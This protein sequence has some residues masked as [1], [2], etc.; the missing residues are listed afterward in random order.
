MPAFNLDKAVAFL[1]GL[2]EDHEN[3]VQD[4]KGFGFRVAA[5]PLKGLMTLKEAQTIVAAFEKNTSELRA[6]VNGLPNGR[7][8]PTE[9]A[10]GLEALYKK[11]QAHLKKF[12]E[13]K[14]KA[15]ETLSKYEDILTGEHFQEAFQAL[16]LA[17]LDLDLTDDADIDFK[18]TLY[19][20]ADP[21]YASGSV[22]VKKGTE[23]VLTINLG[24]R[25]SDDRYWGNI[26]VRKQ[27]WSEKSYKD[28][29]SKMGHAFL[30]RFIRELTSQVKALADKT[31][32]GVFKSRKKF[33]L[34]V[35]D[36]ETLKKELHEKI[37]NT[38]KGKWQPGDFGEPT[39]QS[40]API[41][42][43]DMSKW[44]FA[45]NWRTWGWNNRTLTSLQEGTGNIAVFDGRRKRLCESFTVTVGGKDWEVV[46]MPELPWKGSFMYRKSP[47]HFDWTAEA[48]TQ[49]FP[50]EWRDDVQRIPIDDLRARARALGVQY[51][52]K[53]ANKKALISQIQA[54]LGKYDPPRELT[55]TTA[56]IRYT[57]TMKP[58]KSKA[59]SKVARRFVAAKRLAL[60]HTAP[61][62]LA[63]RYLTAGGA[64]FVTFS[65]GEDANRAFR[66]AVDQAKHEHGHGGYTGTIAEAYDFK[67]KSRTPM[68]ES[69]AYAYA[70]AH[71]DDY[72]K[73]DCGAVPI[74]K[75]VVLKREPVT[76]Q[77]E[78]RNEKEA[79]RKG[80][81]LIK[82]TGRIPPGVSVVVGKAAAKPL[83]GGKGFSVTAERRLSKVGGIT[84]WLFF[85]WAS[86]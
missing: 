13:D 54:G 52:P 71:V 27:S 56:L 5:S 21:A 14:K 77:V 34:T 10:Q 25:A 35:L 66:D 37:W 23:T 19:L 1:D 11:A 9:L 7:G 31:E 38:L 33:D 32:L 78:A 64:Q 49:K 40:L 28:V 47:E 26:V 58:S 41:R 57:V 51:D 72:D 45:H 67:V 44:A 48:L 12:E 24:Y 22:F 76:V 59:A 81:L 16:R 3:L 15:Q 42:D 85:G 83:P 50:L 36:A 70:D 60:R 30:P 62:R 69:D 6:F 73:G 8:L 18:T 74:S 4:A 75:E 46:G 55:L 84:G 61:K 2:V 17:V 80:T 79:L 65:E 20:D 29:A 43:G 82:A 39:Y 53:S 68:S 86:S 63:Q